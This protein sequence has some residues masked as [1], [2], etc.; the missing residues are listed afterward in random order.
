M[1]RFLVSTLV[2]HGYRSVHLGT[3]SSARSRMSGLE[4]DLVVLDVAHPG[5]DGVGFTTRL[6]QWTSAPIVAV[7]NPSREE[8]RAAVLEAGANDY[9]VKPFGT[10]DLLARVRVWLKQGGLGGP[11]GSSEAPTAHLRIDRERRCVIV[12][13]H[14]V[15]MTPLEYKLLEN[16]ARLG[17]NGATEEQILL[18][19]WGPS[20]SP[21]LRYLR[22]H[23]RQLRQKIERDPAR[24]RHLLSEPGGR[25]SLKLG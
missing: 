3:R 17:S 4:P 15:H 13:G 2:A 19:V 14:E 11:R 23:I 6:R 7:L 18:T 21:P 9:L 1:R 20:D 8:E 10:G 22:A 12:D 16:L 24:P 25:Y 5:I